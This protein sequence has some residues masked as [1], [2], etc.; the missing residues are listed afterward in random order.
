MLN[1]NNKN[2]SLI[3]IIALLSYCSMP[4]FLAHNMEALWQEF[5]W[6]GVGGQ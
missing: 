1:C 6:H 2:S 4:S 5:G 3:L